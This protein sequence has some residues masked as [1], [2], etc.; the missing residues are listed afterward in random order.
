MQGTK[1]EGTARAPSTV[2]TFSIFPTLALSKSG[3]GSKP[4]SFLSAGFSQL[5]V[6]VIYGLIIQLHEWE[7][8]K[9]LR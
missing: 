1:K 9:I 8:K 4:V 5:P 6:F 3:Y 2:L 7:G